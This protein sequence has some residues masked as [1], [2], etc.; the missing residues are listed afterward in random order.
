M[1]EP[2]TRI[3]EKA[4]RTPAGV[5]P[6]PRKGIARPWLQVVLILGLFGAAVWVA[7]DGW[8]LWAILLTVAGVAFLGSFILRWMVGDEYGRS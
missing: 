3:E 4:S 2:D 1:G 6:A 7:L 5:L 8:R